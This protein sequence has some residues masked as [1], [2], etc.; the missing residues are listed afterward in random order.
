MVNILLAVAPQIIISP[1]N[2]TV[3]NGNTVI[4]NCM[5]SGDPVPTVS[6]RRGTVQQSNSS[7][8]TIYT[9]RVTEAGVNFVQSILEICSVGTTT[10]GQYSCTVS[11][12]LGAAVASAVVGPGVNT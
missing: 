12:V 9:E 11:S 2:A 4:L 3:G 6:W 5:G 1:G 8:I 7:T 10:D